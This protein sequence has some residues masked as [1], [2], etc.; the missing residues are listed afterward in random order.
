M[1]R[2]EEPQLEHS[3]RVLRERGNMS[4]A[5]LPH[6]WFELANDASVRAGTYVVSLAFGPGLTMCGAVLRKTA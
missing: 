1:L 2:L 4:S 6:I 3:R 5:T